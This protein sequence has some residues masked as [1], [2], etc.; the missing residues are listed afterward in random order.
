MAINVK[1]LLKIIADQDNRANTL[2][3]NEVRPL[4]EKYQT[5]DL[6]EV[7]MGDFVELVNQLRP[8]RK[9]TLTVQIEERRKEVWKL[10]VA[11]VSHEE[12]AKKLG[13]DK[14]TIIRDCNAMGLKKT[15]IS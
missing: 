9:R 6:D 13:F 7:G 2:S 8:P 15:P 1:R 3:Y 4:L 12:I 5:Y 14:R 10:Y 11:G